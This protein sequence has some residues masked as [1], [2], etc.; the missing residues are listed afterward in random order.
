MRRVKCRT[1]IALLLLVIG[2]SQAA[3]AADDRAGMVD[4]FANPPDECRPRTRWW[5]MGNAVTKDEISWQL[6]QMHSQGIR[7]VEQITMEPMYEKGDVPYLSDEYFDLLN[8]AVAE[9]RELGMTV[10]LNFGG[11]GWIWEGDWIPPE[12]RNQTMLSSSFVVSGPANI[13]Q[14]LP[15]DA[16]INPRDVPRSCREIKPDDRLIAVVAG[17]VTD[18]AIDPDSLQ[19]LTGHVQGRRI[20]WQAPEGTWRIMAFWSTILDNAVNHIDKQAMANYI[21]Y[22]G[23]KYAGALGDELGKTVESLFGD[24]FEVPI[25]RNGFYWCDSI[26]AEFQEIKGYDLIKHLPAI[27]WE[28]GSISPKIR[29]DINDVLA[30]MGMEAF[31]DTFATWCHAHGVKSRVQPYGFVT[32]NL[33]GAGAADIP[34]MEVTAGEKDAVPWFDPRVGPREYVASGAHVYG[35][36]IVS[37]EAYTFIHWQPYRATLEELKIASD[38]FLRSGANLFYNHGF[39]ATPE[40]DI[41]PSRGFYPQIHISPDN[42]WWPYY[43][44]LSGYIGRCC[45]MLR[46]G[47]FVAD[48]AVYSPLANQ[49]TQDALNAR[50]WTRDFD[51]GDLNALLIGNGYS[52]DLVNDES[53]QRLS[54]FDGQSLEIGEMTYRVLIVPN[55]AAMPLESLRQI[56]AYAKQGGV[57]IALERVPEASCGLRNWQA[58]DEEVRAIAARLFESPKGM[59]GNGRHSY[60]QGTTYWVDNVLDRRDP[61]E[62]RSSLLDPFLNAIRNHIAPDMAIDFAREGWRENPGLCFIHRKQDDR[63]VY[64]VANVQDRPVDLPVAFRVADAVPW[65]WNPCTGRVQPLFEYEERDGAVWVPVRLAPYESTFIVFEKNDERPHAVSSSLAWIEHVDERSVTGW[66]D[67]EG[68]H[69]VNM[70]HGE[71]FRAQ[72]Q[73]VPAPLRISPSWRLVLESPVFARRE[74]QLDELV[75]WTD[76]PD[77]PR[78]PE[79]RHFSGAGVYA[80]EFNLSEQYVQ[81]DVKLYLDLGDV[82]NVADV[83]LNGKPAGTV[84]MCG[85]RLNISAQALTG[86]N[87]IELRVTNTLINRV[88][89]LTEFP[90]VPKELEPRLGRGVQDDRSAAQALLGFSPLPR[91]GLLG[92]VEIHP[93][94]RLEIPCTN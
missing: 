24:S 40:R 90:A 58:D 35:R 75:S 27:W 61:L 21:E 28:V 31:F 46:Q 25:H 20:V 84:W 5:W 16:T 76:L 49:W 12:E 57:V 82:G 71:V 79:A 42:V 89:G 74:F 38:M 44:L 93:Y 17:R 66:T 9:A 18:G 85:Q 32:D 83:N 22:V 91:S 43:H 29:Y 52:Y 86:T 34:E 92:P 53:M 30:Q 68:G 7:G 72:A 65:Q 80:A 48:V 3:A 36:N 8:H 94:K 41:T 56:E 15:T 59:D 73:Q 2:L 11:P 13:D 78:L 67:R 55:V 87:N 14:E 81:E 45:Y 39:L 77:A 88:A 69:C 60:G 1:T 6:Q 63:D 70:G 33:E 54:S 10:S 23:A 50:R 51:W 19:V 64:F 62:R 26:P 37:V 47:R 4:Q